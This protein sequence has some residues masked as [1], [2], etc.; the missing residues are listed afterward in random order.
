MW[1][2]LLLE[3]EPFVRR[4]I[5]QAVNWEA[6]GF[7]VVAEAE[8]GSEAWGL[9]QAQQVDVVLS[10]I[11]MPIMNGIELIRMAKQNGHEAEF[12]MLTCVNEFEY[13]RLALQYGAVGYL[14]KASM[15]VEELQAILLKIKQ[16][17]I[18]KRDQRTRAPMFNLYHKIW[19][20][21]HGL[22]EME[23]KEDEEG[24][25][26]LP[27]YVRLFVGSANNV[28]SGNDQMI[29]LFN[30][31]CRDK[32]LVHRFVS[33]GIETIFVWSDEKDIPLTSF[34]MQLTSTPW[35]TSDSLIEGW[36]SLL[37]E[38]GRTWY[39]LDPSLRTMGGLQVENV[40]WKKEPLILSQFE[41]AQWAECEKSLQ[42][43]WHCF[44]KQ[45]MAVVM[46]KKAADRL[47]K[48]FAR[49]SNQSPAGKAAWAAVES[50]GQAL[51][52]LI[53]RVRHYSN[54]RMKETL[55]DHP[56]VN[57]IIEYVNRH[58]DKELTL[59]GMAKY[60]NMGEQYLSGL[61]KKKTGEQFIQY[62][63]RIRIERACY[64]LAET[65]LRVAEICEQV[66]FVHLN[67]F[68]KQFKKW[69][70]VTPSEFRESKKAERKKRLDAEE[71]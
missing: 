2:L 1:N 35:Q 52:Q 60:V 62:V 51:E 63:Q 4:S 25:P 69:T 58:Y 65:E 18:K 44:K 31:N 47:D 29:G 70:G 5:R 42:T 54:H 61:F 46:V 38:M 48:S 14:L 57:K 27:A 16:S 49:L 23:Q 66:G 28:L 10:D 24:L 50:H 11:M 9:M 30:T 32:L 22:E 39:E 34:P 40:A 55:T 68:L 37:Q 7:R 64:C 26:P 53:N 67:Y 41:A 8:D 6:L 59:K 19:R 17:L 45:Q 56:E 20:S 21:I 13:A 15:D 36:V 43:V 3:D 71:M 12:V 33:W